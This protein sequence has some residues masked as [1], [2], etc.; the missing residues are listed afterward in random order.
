VA[1]T[2][3]IQGRATAFTE[4]ADMRNIDTLPLFAATDLA[5]DMIRA[6]NCDFC[7]ADDAIIFRK[8]EKQRLPTLNPEQ[9]QTLYA[10]WQDRYAAKRAQDRNKATSRATSRSKRGRIHHPRRSNAY[11]GRDQRPHGPGV[12]ADSPAALSGGRRGAYRAR[13]A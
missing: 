5:A 4:A 7:P 11:A 13:T 9:V 3:G 2:V 6:T 12:H 8:L 10:E 1:G